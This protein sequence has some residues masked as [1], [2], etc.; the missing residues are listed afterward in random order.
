M[1]PADKIWC[2]RWRNAELGKIRFEFGTKNADLPYYPYMFP[3]NKQ[4]ISLCRS[5]M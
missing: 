3:L 5:K 1:I 4:F 2:D